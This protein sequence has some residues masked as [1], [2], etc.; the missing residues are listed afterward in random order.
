MLDEK[1]VLSL[2]LGQTD[3]E[4]RFCSFMGMAENALP[5]VQH[6]LF[7]LITSVRLL[8]Y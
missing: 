8:L 5:Q 6:A 4:R 3:W 1:P 7:F 2:F